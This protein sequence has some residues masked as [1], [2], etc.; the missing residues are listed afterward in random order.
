MAEK[1]PSKTDDQKLVAE[2]RERLDGSINDAKKQFT[3]LLSAAQDQLAYAKQQ[4]ARW[5][6]ERD[7]LL[8]FKSDVSKP[9]NNIYVSVDLLHQ[10]YTA[11]QK[12]LDIEIAAYQHN[13]KSLATDA[14]GSANSLKVP[15]EN[16]EHAE[17]L[18]RMK[19]SM[20]RYLVRYNIEGIDAVLRA[21]NQ[22]NTINPVNEADR[23][24]RVAR[25]DE[26]KAA[27]AGGK[28][29]QT[30]VEQLGNELKTVR[31]LNKWGMDSF[32]RFATLDAAGKA[33][34]LRDPKWTRLGDKI[35]VL[36]EL[37]DRTANVPAMGQYFVVWKQEKLPFTP[38]IKIEPAAAP[39]VAKKGA[40]ATTVKP[41][42]GSRSSGLKLK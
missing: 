33:A 7:R 38:L 40:D 10:F 3:V 30:Q 17:A 5:A 14:V 15:N 34:V 16:L 1:A 37:H 8:P 24:K 2:A 28:L 26:I 23:K 12:A 35:R 4:I 27:M 20:T 21:T 36:Q 22:G 25:G 31:E 13:L 18:C 29:V 39:P 41:A 6:A 19:L 9:E 11:W 42:T 32:K